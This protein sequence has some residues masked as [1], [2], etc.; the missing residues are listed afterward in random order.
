MPPPCPYAATADVRTI[1]S[2]A[3]TTVV[4]T[5]MTTPEES[6]RSGQPLMLTAFTRTG[7]MTTLTRDTP[8]GS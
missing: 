7:R 1:A 4:P 3:S 6:A 2:E 5:F 8:G